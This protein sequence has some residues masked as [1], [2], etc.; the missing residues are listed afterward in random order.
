MSAKEW[1]CRVDWK[2]GEKVFLQVRIAAEWIFETKN[3]VQ[4]ST[5][6]RQEELDLKIKHIINT[7][8]S[9]RL[10]I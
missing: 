10:K 7:T 3:I 8:A 9:L 4:L 1:Q 6:V 5:E 2:N